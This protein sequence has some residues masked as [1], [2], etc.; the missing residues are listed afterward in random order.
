M[1]YLLVTIFIA[2]VAYYVDNF[3]RSRPLKNV[4]QAS[5][6]AELIRVLLDLD[7]VALEELFRLYQQQFGAGAARYARHT[8]LKWKAGEVRPNHE[9]FRRFLL[10][11]PKVM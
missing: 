9:T 8:Y 1:D 6:N 2:V 3:I 11:L 7:A 5:Q 4:S 10:Y